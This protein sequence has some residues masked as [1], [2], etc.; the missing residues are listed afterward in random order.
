MGLICYIIVAP[1]FL[2]QAKEHLKLDQPGSVR[3]EDASKCGLS[4]HTIK[5]WDS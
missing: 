5:L 3:R 4:N 2:F 1:P